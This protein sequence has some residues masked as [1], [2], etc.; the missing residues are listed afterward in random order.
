MGKVLSIAPVRS[1]KVMVKT[2]G[3]NRIIFRNMCDA[4][5]KLLTVKELS[6]VNIL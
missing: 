4:E 2:G 5:R 1:H 3:S 6:S